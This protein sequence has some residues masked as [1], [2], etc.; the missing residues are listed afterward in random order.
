MSPKNP[1]KIRIQNQ[2]SRRAGVC[3]STTSKH[4]HTDNDGV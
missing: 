2:K 3:T 1:E 4:K